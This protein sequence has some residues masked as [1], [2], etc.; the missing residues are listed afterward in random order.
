M[1]FFSLLVALWL[2]LPASA[3]SVAVLPLDQGAKSDT[4][5]G[6]G[7][8]LAGMLISDLSR[9]E[10]LELVERARLDALLQE[11]ELGESG[12]VDPK[13]A[14]KLGS[15]VGAEWVIVGSWS[16]VNDAFLMDARTVDVGSG[17]IVAAV[18]ANGTVDDFITVE[19]T[20][21]ETLLEELE[22][23]V[24]AGARRKIIAEAPTE[25]FDALS[26]YA[27]WN[28]CFAAS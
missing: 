22:V 10:G 25:D 3:R 18:D 11:I 4:H 8:A 16:V 28:R 1:R 6:L 21:V 9:V 15:G 17:K 24:S 19:K 5:A 7:R 14:A 20:L 12:F 23:A 26:T 2:S 27:A 13:S